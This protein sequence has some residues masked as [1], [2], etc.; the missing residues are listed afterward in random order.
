MVYELEAM[1][2]TG[3]EFIDVGRGFS[4]GFVVFDLFLR[5]AGHREEARALGQRV[6][7]AQSHDPAREVHVVRV[8]HVTEAD[9]ALEGA[10][11]T[12]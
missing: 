1:H 8:V 9:L 5:V 12:G 3:R 2:D 7:I 11:A 6:V 4:L 10:V